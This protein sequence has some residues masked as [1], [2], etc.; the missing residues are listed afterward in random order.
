MPTILLSARVMFIRTRSS[1]LANQD[2]LMQEEV[3]LVH[4]PG[5]I[6]AQST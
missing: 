2:L 4:M 3:R 6:F 5:L 1:A